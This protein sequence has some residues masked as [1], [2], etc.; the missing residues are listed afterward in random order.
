M[1]GDCFPSVAIRSCFSNTFSEFRCILRSSQVRF[2][3]PTSR[4]PPLG[5]ARLAVSHLHR[6]Y[7]HAP[8]PA[9]HP[10]L[11]RFLRLAIPTELCVLIWTVAR[12]G[13]P[14]LSLHGVP[15][16]FFSW[17]QQVLPSSCVTPIPV[18]TCS[19]DSGRR[20]GSLPYRI[21]NLGPQ[22][23]QHEDAFDSHFGAQ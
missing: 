5:P 21:Q 15:S 11:L 10:A 14:G 17:R 19:L 1:S 16:H 20:S 8:T 2:V 18:R 22:L 4:F 7:Q 12:S 23:T 3:H 13:Q 6:Y 9:A